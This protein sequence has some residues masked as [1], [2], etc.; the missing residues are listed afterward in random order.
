MGGFGGEGG[1]FDLFSWYTNIPPVSRIYFTSAFLTTSMCAMDLLN[2][3]VLYYDVHLIFIEGQIW[4]L[5]SSFLFFG[6]FSV[7]FVFH[8]YFLV[9]HCRQLEDGDFR[10]K[11]SNFVLFIAFG[12]ITICSLAPWILKSHPFL[13]SALTF[14]MTYVWGRRNEDVRMT[15]LGLISFTAPYLPWVMVCFNWI[16]GNSV[17]MSLMGICVGHMYYFLEYVYPVVADVRGWRLK[18]IMVP[19]RWLRYI[20][21]ERDANAIMQGGVMLRNDEPHLHVD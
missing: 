13:G 20:C 12:V 16:V 1:E 4:R 3:Y 7:D 17:R 10:G 8:M 18:K 9:R 5:F 21:G 11:P 15:M 19:P 6:L 2:P 14:M